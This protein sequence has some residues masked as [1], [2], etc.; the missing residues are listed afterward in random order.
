LIFT[1]DGGKGTSSVWRLVAGR[2]HHFALPNVRV[3]VTGY[4]MNQ[5]VTTLGQNAVVYADTAWGR[6]CGRARS[7]P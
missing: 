5:E 6:L 3:P 1:W 2:L 4:Q 7:P